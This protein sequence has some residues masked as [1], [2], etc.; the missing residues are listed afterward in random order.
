MVAGDKR[1][2]GLQRDRLYL[3]WNIFSFMIMA[4]L[5]TQLSKLINLYTL[6]RWLVSIN[7]RDITINLIPG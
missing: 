7:W 6:N 1:K 3:G 2:D 4:S 5:V